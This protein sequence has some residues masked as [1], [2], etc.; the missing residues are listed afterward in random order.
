MAMGKVVRGRVVLDDNAPQLVVPFRDNAEL[1]AHVA[2]LGYLDGSVLDA[3]YGL[4]TFWK[5]FKPETLVTND[6]YKPAD[7]AWDFL[8]L[9]CRGGEYDTVVYDPDYKLNGTPALEEMDARYGVDGDMV[10][11]EKRLDKMTVGAIECYRVARKFLLVKCMDM[12]EGGKIR[13]QSDLVTRAV[14]DVGGE[15][16]ARFMLHYVPM[17]QPPSWR[18]TPLDGKVKPRTF[19]SGNAE[20]DARLWVTEQGGGEVAQNRQV[21]AAN[22]YSSLLVFK[23]RDYAPRRLL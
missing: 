13:W 11:R 7:K 5:D 1:I 6:L 21:T 18:A 8:D 19:R 3:T 15:K 14:E 12:V 4:G 10:N 17:P 20:R 22:N 9:P 16:V 23:R 2:R